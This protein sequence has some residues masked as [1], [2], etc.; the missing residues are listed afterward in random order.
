MVAKLVNCEYNTF[1][2]IYALPLNVNA[3]LRLEIDDEVNG[4]IYIEVGYSSYMVVLVLN[5]RM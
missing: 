1:T 2:F 3:K 5:D 4:G